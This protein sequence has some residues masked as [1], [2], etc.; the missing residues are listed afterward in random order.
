MNILEQI[1]N[2]ANTSHKDDWSD[3]VTGKAILTPEQEATFLRG[4]Q[5]ADPI[6]TLST[7]KL[8]NKPSRQGSRFSISRG[9]LQWGYSSGHTTNTNLHEAEKNFV[10]QEIQ[11]TKMKAVT[12]Y[13]DDEME[14][15]IEQQS[16]QQTLLSEM[17]YILGL[18]NAEWHVFG[19]T[20]LNNTKDPN[21]CLRAGDGWIKRTNSNNILQSKGI[22]STDGAF[23][24]NDGVETMFDAMRAALPIEARQKVATQGVFLCPF[25]IEDAYRNSQIGRYTPLGDSKLEGYDGLKYKGIPVIYSP[26]LDSEI[27]Q[28]IDETATCILTTPDNLEQNVFKQM[29][30]EFERKVNEEITNVFFRYK[31]MPSLVHDEYIVCAKIGLDEKAGIQSAN[32][33]KPVV[34]IEQA[35]SG[36]NPG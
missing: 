19:D 11:T 10:G 20:T 35:V 13:T 3:M 33:N 9:A 12:S 30:A 4:L 14:E 5:I 16:F 36:S 23:D 29:T 8:M 24:I 25:E 34:T 2:L 15:N 27:G 32:F 7:L 26:T 18:D 6:M 31:A 17:S 22:D 28:A 21:K 1:D